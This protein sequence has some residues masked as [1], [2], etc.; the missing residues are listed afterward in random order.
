VLVL[1]RLAHFT[2]VR[3]PLRFARVRTNGRAG[4][5]SA[6][7]S[8]VPPEVRTQDELMAH[9]AFL[10]VELREAR[11]VIGEEVVAGRVGAPDLDR[12]LLPFFPD[13]GGIPS[14]SARAIVQYGED[15]EAWQFPSAVE[16]ITSGAGGAHWALTLPR[17]VFARRHR[18]TRRHPT[19]GEWSFQPGG[20]GALQGRGQLPLL[21]VSVGG[22]SVV[23]G[24]EGRV[25]G[26]SGHTAVGTLYGPDRIRLRVRA[27]VRRLW[28]DNDHGLI[29]G[30]VFR[31]FGMR[32][33]MLLAR[34]LAEVGGD[35]ST[36]SAG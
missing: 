26:I 15:N 24:A 29:A 33:H 32:N 31:A 7:K 8:Q 14:G 22:F 2:P 23:I 30:C 10:S 16:T 9:L 5:S 35:T 25:D 19:A 6:V 34:Y 20:A 27:E 12:R 17:Q 21:D 3:P 18:L 13:D 28:V 36:V 11:V 4:F 1:A